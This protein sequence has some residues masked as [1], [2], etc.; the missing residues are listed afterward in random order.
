MGGSYP[1]PFRGGMGATFPSPNPGPGR[2]RRKRG[3][4]FDRRPLPLRPGP[5][6]QPRKS[7]PIKPVPPPGPAPYDPGPWD[8]PEIPTAP[9]KWAKHL[10]RLNG[11]LRGLYALEQ[12]NE[13]YWL[14]GQYEWPFRFPSGWYLYCQTNVPGQTKYGSA[15]GHTVACGTT[16]QV[17]DGD[18]DEI[19]RSGVQVEIG[20]SG[21]QWHIGRPMTFDLRMI[22]DTVWRVDPVPE[23]KPI[24]IYPWPY[25][26]PLAIPRPQPLLVPEFFPPGQ[27]WH[28]P[29]EVPQRTPPPRPLA[30]PPSLKPQDQQAPRPLEGPPPLPRPAIAEPPPA[31]TRERKFR[32]PPGA[33]GRFVGELAGAITEASDLVDALFEG[34]PYW[35]RKRY[36]KAALLTKVKI[37][38]DQY[39]KID[40]NRAIDAIVENQLEDYIIGKFG[41][42]V[43]DGIMNA[44]DQGYWRHPV[45]PGTGPAL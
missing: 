15:P 12:L 34:L 10:G 20:A 33:F 25:P 27:I 7:P 6:R 37:L 42:A 28:P 22:L 40:P 21:A 16:N 41:Q 24:T 1:R 26:Y 32:S 23:P 3:G 19:S 2:Q 39:D 13:W 45:G 38:Y 9:A 11:Y 31:R 4:S 36:G 8:M 30:L 29:I 17:P 14:R 5:H 35:M 43:K 44:A 18:V